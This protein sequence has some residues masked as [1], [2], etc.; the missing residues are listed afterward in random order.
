MVE[1]PRS[2]PRPLVKIN[3]WV[4]VISVLVT[5]LTGAAW[6]LL[7]PLIA[8]LSGIL[9]GYNPIM[10]LAKRFLKKPKESYIPEEWGQQQFNQKIAVFCLGAGWLSF[11]LNWNTAGYIFT[12]MVAIAAFIAILGF[13]IG[14]FILFQWKQFQ[15]RRTQS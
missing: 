14:C 6:F 1:F 13:C 12:A 4:I 15:Y 9:F 11:L 8:G 5:W 10:Q 7:I 3:Q 2:I